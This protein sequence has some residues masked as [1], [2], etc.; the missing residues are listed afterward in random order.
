MILPVSRRE[1]LKLGGAAALAVAFRGVAH[2]GRTGVPVLMYHDIS[3]DYRDDYTISPALFSAHMEWLHGN[4]FR[5]VSLKD[6][7]SV[8]A[9]GRTFVLTFDDGYASFLDYAFPL[10][11][12][13]G[14]RATINVLG[15]FAGEVIEFRGKRAALSWDEYRHLV[16]SGRVDLGCH[17]Y[18]L[19]RFSERGAAG[20]PAGRLEE[21]LRRFQESVTAET[22]SPSEI[23]AWPYGLYTENGI[24]VAR[25]AGFRYLLTSEEGKFVPGGD[26]TRIPRL[27]INHKFDPISFRQ[28]VEEPL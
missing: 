25:K 15:R 22:G 2:G 4:G 17:T 13:Y 16:R 6:L 21:D 28:Y 27:N 3:Q 23:L 14:F 24:A 20:V 9:H 10:L 18:D 11:E 26:V 19:H 12:E 8:S 7:P 1:F 5:S